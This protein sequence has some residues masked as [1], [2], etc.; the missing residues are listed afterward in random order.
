M[1][2]ESKSL[3]GLLTTPPAAVVPVMPVI[4]DLQ[5]FLEQTMTE[6]AGRGRIR[7]QVTTEDWKAIIGIKAGEHVRIAGYAEGKWTANQRANLKAGAIV[8]IVF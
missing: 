3:A 5:P 7:L 2:L 1:P 6:T 4:L 8:D